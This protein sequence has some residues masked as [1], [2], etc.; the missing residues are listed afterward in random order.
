LKEEIRRISALERFTEST[1]V[2]YLILRGLQ[3]YAKD[4]KLFS[5]VSDDVWLE[6]ILK[7]SQARRKS[8]VA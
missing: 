1:V 2:F 8:R 7:G 4:G 6:E 5:A 3:A